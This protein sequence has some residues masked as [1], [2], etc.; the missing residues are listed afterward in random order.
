M[1][2]ARTQSRPQQL[3]G[4]YRGSGPFRYLLPLR[5]IHPG[6][7]RLRIVPGWLPTDLTRHARERKRVHGVVCEIELPEGVTLIGDTPRKVP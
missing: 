1:T 3:Q 6:T 5:R 4:V 7:A 2:V